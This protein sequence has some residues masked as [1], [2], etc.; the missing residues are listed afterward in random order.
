VIDGVHRLLAARL[1]SR[2]TISV[3]FFDGTHD[4]ALV[5]AV[6]SNVAHGKPLTLSEREAATTNILRL[7]PDWSNRRIGD[8][9]GLSDKTVD[10]LRKAG[11][12]I[13]Q[14]SVRVGRDGRLRRTDSQEVRHEI[15]EALKA[16]PSTGVRELAQSLATSPATVRD[17]RNRM[18]RGG[19]LASSLNQSG[20]VCR[21]PQNS[22]DQMR[23]LS[24]KTETRWDGDRALLSMSDGNEF[25]A[26]LDAS[27][28]LASHWSR[29][30]AEIPAG[31]IPAIIAVARSRAHQWNAFATSLEERSR[32]MNRH[33]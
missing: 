2:K 31:R 21:H 4:E 16:K 27:E 26:W 23:L 6:R 1:L 9:C 10:R 3:Q 25:A 33:S 8:V 29:S 32:E 17:V 30:I 20:D 12:E 13:P 5:E 28:I 22:G 19:A 18:Q 15:A 7:H 24:E 11:A 14:L